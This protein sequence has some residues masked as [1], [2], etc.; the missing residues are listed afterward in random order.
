MR[1]RCKS[2]PRSSCDK[3]AASE[4]SELEV[5]GQGRDRTDMSSRGEDEDIAE[6]DDLQRG[7]G[8]NGRR[9]GGEGTFSCWMCLRSL[10]SR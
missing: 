7:V 4:K 1:R 6:G 8:C 3:V 5:A 9:R 10:S 2:V